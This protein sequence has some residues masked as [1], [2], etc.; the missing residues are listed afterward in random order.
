MK[1]GMVGIS[2][3]SGMRGRVGIGGEVWLYGRSYKLWRKGLGYGLS[4]ADGEM[5][6]VGEIL[7]VVRR[8]EG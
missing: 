3:A 6:G 5:A 1:E 4:V 8:Y 2:D 7:D